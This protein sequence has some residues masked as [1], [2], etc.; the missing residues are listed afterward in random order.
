MRSSVVVGVVALA[1][2]PDRGEDL[3]DG[4]GLDPAPACSIVVEEASPRDGA[5]DGTFHLRSV[6]PDRCLSAR[7]PGR[8][9]AGGVYARGE[10]GERVEVVLRLGGRTPVVRGIVRE[11]GGGPL[12]GASVFL[13]YSSGHRFTR[14][15]RCRLL[16]CTS[17]RTG[18]DASS[19]TPSRCTRDSTPG[20]AP[21]AFTI[22]HVELEPEG[23]EGEVW[24]ELELHRAAR[25]TGVAREASG[26]PIEHVFTRALQD[27]ISP[28]PGMGYAGRTG[29]RSTDVGRGRDVRHGGPSPRRGG[30]DGEDDAR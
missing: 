3:R 11:A 15:W 22:E 25:V 4:G 19:A 5:T 16:R 2:C 17:G 8:R 10:P 9:A 26:Q 20:R 28:A 21:T 18:R 29:G 6:E 7:V 30:G 23:E 12:A 13:G 14:V 24:V 1:G 27:G